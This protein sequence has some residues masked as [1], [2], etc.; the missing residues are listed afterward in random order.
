MSEPKRPGPAPRPSRKKPRSRTEKET[1]AMAPT[2]EADSEMP[3]EMQ[4]SQESDASYD[5]EPRIPSK[6]HADEG[7]IRSNSG[8]ADYDRSSDSRDSSPSTE[9]SN[10][11]SDR[12]E[13]EGDNR[14]PVAPQMRF[15]P[16]DEYAFQV[17]Y[18]RGA[19]SFCGTVLE[20][21]DLKATGT[22]KQDV[23]EELE[24]QLEIH[25][26]D[27]K[28]RGETTPEAFFARRYP[29]VLEAHISPTLFRR[30]DLLS[31]QE[32]VRSRSP[33]R[34]ASCGRR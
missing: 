23:V 28:R 32:K 22:S 34:R 6:S 33:R 2:S 4:E 30:L 7:D 15:R 3:R 11:H 26:Q 9:G 24:S 13:N 14:A 10:G 31:R 17:Y 8:D 21:P 1:S 12:Y 18:D 29:E 27:L 16:S 25:L 19:R 20:F 5:N